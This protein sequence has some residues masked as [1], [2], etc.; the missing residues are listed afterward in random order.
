LICY[1]P[2]MYPLGF[3]VKFCIGV[4]HILYEITK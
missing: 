3:A 2:R 1:R 4:F